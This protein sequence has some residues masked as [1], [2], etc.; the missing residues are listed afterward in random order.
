[1]PMSIRTIRRAAFAAVMFAALL[2]PV[3]ILYT[4]FDPARLGAAAT[5]EMLV[6]LSLLSAPLIGYGILRAE[7][8]AR[9]RVQSVQ[10]A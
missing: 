6:I 10:P 4:S 1:M 9:A 7:R 5:G 8:T 2:I 3:A